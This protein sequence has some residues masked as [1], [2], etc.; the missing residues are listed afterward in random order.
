MESRNYTGSKRERVKV[1]DK[2][3]EKEEKPKEAPQSETVQ[4][5][6]LRDLKLNYTGSVTGKVYRFDGAGSVRDDIDIRDS[7][8]MLEKNGGVCCEG[9]GSTQPQP[10]FAKV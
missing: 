7:I 1:S 8:K 9:S 4:L 10:Y 6:L 3:V 2:K 5:V